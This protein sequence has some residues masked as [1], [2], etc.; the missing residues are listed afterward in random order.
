MQGP[1]CYPPMSHRIFGEKLSSCV[2]SFQTSCKVFLK[3]YLRTWLISSFPPKVFGCSTFVHIP[4]QHWS[5]L[6]PKATKCIFLWYSPNQKGYKCYSPITKKFYTSMN[7]I[8]WKSVLLL[9]NWYL[10]GEYNSGI[11]ILGNRNHDRTLKHSS[12]LLYTILTLS[13]LLQVSHSKLLNP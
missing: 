10:E 7:D 8:F 12:L 13:L 1:S 5:K 9:Q 3:S 4:Q 2:L 6:D 11:P